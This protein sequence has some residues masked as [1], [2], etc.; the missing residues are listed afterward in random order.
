MNK[1]TIYKVKNRSDGSVIYTIPEL[2]NLRR[3]YGP[4]ETK[5]IPYK[6]L[7]ALYYLPGGITMIREY[8]QVTEKEALDALNIDVEPEYNMSEQDI[9]ELMTTGSLDAFLDTLDFA[10]DGVVDLIKKFAVRLPLNDVAKRKALLE[11]TGFDTERAIMNDIASREPEPAATADKP[12][13]RRV[14]PATTEGP[15]RRTTPKYTVVSKS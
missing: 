3:V 11:K 13:G 8:L 4:G 6:E 2:N 12:T 14:Q 7:E 15:V 10:P 1:D 5:E 9:I